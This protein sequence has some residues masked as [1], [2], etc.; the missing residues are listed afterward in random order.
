MVAFE[1][2]IVE[3][4]SWYT[5]P[6]TETAGPGVES[7]VG[8]LVDVSVEVGT[9]VE[10]RVAVMVWMLV[11]VELG[12]SVFVYVHEGVI[13]KVG[14]FDCV[15]VA[16]IVTVPYGVVEKVFVGVNTGAA[17]VSVTVN[18][19][20]GKTRGSTGSYFLAQPVNI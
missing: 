10:V 16:V 15:K 18:V 4:S 14:V 5:V 12:P 2:G 13:V 7:I 8:V 19:L 11:L 20:N 3:A 17:G 6:E 1:I 9:K